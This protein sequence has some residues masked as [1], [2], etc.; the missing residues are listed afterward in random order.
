[1]YFVIRQ[2]VNIMENKSHMEVTC[3]AAA[4]SSYDAMRYPRQFDRPCLMTALATALSPALVPVVRTPL[5]PTIAA[6]L[7]DEQSKLKVSCPLTYGQL[8]SNVFLKYKKEEER[9]QQTEGDPEGGNPGDQSGLRRRRKKDS[10]I[11]MTS[12]QFR[13]EFG[14]DCRPLQEEPEDT[15][16]CWEKFK[17]GAA[18]V[19]SFF[20][21][22]YTFLPTSRMCGIWEVVVAVSVFITVFTISLQAAFFHFHPILWIVNYSIELIFVI[23]MFLKFHTGYYT[24]DGILVTKPLACAKHYLKTNFRYDLLAFFPF[25]LVAVAAWP[26]PIEGV[27]RVISL[28]RVSKMIRIYRLPLG[29]EYLEEKI[30]NTSG[31]IKEIKFAVYML[32]GT[33]WMACLWFFL[34][35]PSIY[36]SAGEGHA[37]EESTWVYRYA[38][39]TN[40]TVGNQSTIYQ[41]VV[42][43]YWAVATTS[44]VGYGDIYAYTDLE[45]IFALMVMIG[46]I[47]AYGYI[48][49]SV[50]ASLANADSTR[51]RFQER[52]T[53]IKNDDTMNSSLKARVLNY[54]EF[55]WKR[56][57]GVS[58]DSLFQG[59]PVSLQADISLSLYKKI[60]DQVRQRCL[61]TSE[62]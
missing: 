31:L 1:M 49:A 14:E 44:N 33:H 56:N 3:A 40:T 11:P 16:T 60:I 51:A 53:A 37:C 20:L 22:R 17:D 26:G 19:F 57:K 32:A 18:R 39:F 30:T 61:G 13:R 8:P 12:S 48:I 54:Y 50:A 43:L 62:D 9:V 59:M 55:S 41:Y 46:G 36:M 6:C 28:A 24:P 45:R 47:V 2:F 21:M 58:F 5:G 35:C 42:S 38:E 34:A 27:T 29:F 25:E 15:R 4:K 52:M 7:G 23:D 10:V